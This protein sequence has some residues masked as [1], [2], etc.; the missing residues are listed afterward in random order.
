MVHMPS[1]FHLHLNSS[2]NFSAD[3]WQYERLST[4]FFLGNMIK[5]EASVRVENH[6][7][8]RVYVD[9]C[10]AAVQPEIQS[11]TSYVLIEKHG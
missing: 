6:V 4:K 7:L 9:S 5:I 10:V 2:L 8:L 11:G 3:D 1:S